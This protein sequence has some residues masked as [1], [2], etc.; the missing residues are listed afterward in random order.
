MKSFTQI[1]EYILLSR[2]E[3]RSHLRLDDEC[4]E[5]GGDSRIFRGLLAHYLKTTIPDHKIYVCHACYNEKCS[6]PNHLYWGTPK[7]NVRDTKESGRWKS[8]H[9]LT[10]EKYGIDSAKEI[11][12]NAAKKAGS[13]GGGHN[14]LTQDEILLWKQAIDVTDIT[15]HGFVKVLSKKMICSHTHVRRILN[16]YFPDIQSF[17]RKSKRESC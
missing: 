2:E 10:I 8:A 3:R 6:N 14:A 15:K 4:I 13:L 11:Y 7:D 12:R 9:Q 1:E 17:K 5:I 16:K